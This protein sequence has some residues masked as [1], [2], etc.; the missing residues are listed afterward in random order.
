[1]RN[2][3]GRGYSRFGD[4]PLFGCWTDRREQGVDAGEVSWAHYGILFLNELPEF[5]RY[6]L[7]VLR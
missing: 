5:R 3:N 2:Q 4:N 7:E 6:M 1:V